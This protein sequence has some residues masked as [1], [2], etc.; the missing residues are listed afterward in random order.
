MIFDGACPRNRGSGGLSV[1]LKVLVHG[2]ALLV[3][4]MPSNDGVVQEDVRFGVR[5]GTKTRSSTRYALFDVPH[6]PLN[7]RP[8]SKSPILRTT[9]T[10]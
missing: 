2:I 10:I 3:D 6:P 8:S 1:I 7:L 4:E 5:L 9:V